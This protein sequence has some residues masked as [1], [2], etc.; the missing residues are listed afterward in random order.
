MALLSL[1]GVS[2]LFSI[3]FDYSDGVWFRKMMHLM[4]SDDTDN[5][6]G[7]HDL[8][9]RYFIHYDDATS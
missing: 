7:S 3:M 4:L 2:E 9:M 5:D 1:L 6:D 8:I